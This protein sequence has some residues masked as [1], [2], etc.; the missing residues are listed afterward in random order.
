MKVYFWGEDGVIRHCSHSLLS[1]V[2]R[3]ISENVSIYRGATST[4]DGLED[5]PEGL[6][7]LWQL[8]RHIE[9]LDSNNTALRDLL[10]KREPE[11]CTR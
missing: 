11:V 4:D 2:A 1:V 7:I 9:S 8:A 10:E 3:A 5:D 6:A